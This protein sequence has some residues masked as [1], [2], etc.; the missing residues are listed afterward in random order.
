MNYEIKEVLYSNLDFKKLCKK[1]DDFQNNIFSERA[2]LKMSALDGLEKLEKILLMYD[3]NK[4]IAC[5]AIKPVS[6]STAELARMY[7]DADYRGQGL[8]KQIIQ[9]I[10]DY[11]KRKG[12]KKIILDTWK[13]STSAR[14]LYSSLGFRER[15]P[16]DAKTFQNSFSTY[17]ETIQN[18][19]QE[20]LVFMELDIF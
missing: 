17:D 8:A 15:P 13:D 12:Y 9:E 16:F 6:D 2:S 7:T 3:E 4:V 19:I 11:A 20:K 5:G 1:L 18:K 14:K 10:I